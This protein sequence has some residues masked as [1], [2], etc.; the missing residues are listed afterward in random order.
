M[1]TA[2]LKK[3]NLNEMTKIKTFNIFILQLVPRFSLYS[4][5]K[6]FYTANKTRY[7]NILKFL[8][9]VPFFSYDSKFMPTWT[10]SDYFLIFRLICFLSLIFTLHIALIYRTSM[11]YI[12]LG[13]DR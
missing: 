7:N 10:Q 11:F 8:I 1:R 13:A 2:Y 5:L 3:K 4:S 9:N 6:M 12:A